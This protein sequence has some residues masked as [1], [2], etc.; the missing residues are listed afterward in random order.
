MYCEDCGMN[1]DMQVLHSPAGYYIGTY[2]INCGP[3]SRDSPYTQ[4]KEEA[5][6]WLSAHLQYS[7]ALDNPSSTCFSCEIKDNC[8]YAFD[9]YNTDGDC[10]ASK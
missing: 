10:I 2:C 9:L 3:H 7:D 5:W 1:L 8:K 6:S 4:D